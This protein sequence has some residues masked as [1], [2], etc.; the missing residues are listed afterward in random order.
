MIRD[1]FIKCIEFYQK[2][3]SPIKSPRCK[4]FPTC[5]SYGIEALKIHGVIK[6]GFLTFY[7]ILRCNPFSSGGY[8]PVPL[9]KT[10]K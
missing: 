3:I 6:G 10:K 8:D 4:Y 2:K 5:S 1:F 9:K 7:R